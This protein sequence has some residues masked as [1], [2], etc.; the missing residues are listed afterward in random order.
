MS[1]PRSHPGAGRVRFGRMAP[2]IAVADL[3][4]SLRFYGE[5]LGFEVVFT[6]GDPVAFAILERDDVELHLTLL[7][8]H[9]A[10]AAN[11]AHLMVDDVTALH[12]HC[13]TH[14]V[15]IVK[16]L[17]DADF[18]LRTFVLADPDG[19]LVDVGEPL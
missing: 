9:T 5:V 17:R 11:V 15:R 4:R 10:S 6:N 16:Q 3:E 12:A 14:D 8:T 19:N 13:E 18:G 1:T 2:T 7:P